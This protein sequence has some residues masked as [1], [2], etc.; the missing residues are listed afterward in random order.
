[1][2]KKG[3]DKDVIFLL[4]TTL[5]MLAT[6]VGLEVYRAYVKVNVAVDVEKHLTILTP[7]LDT[8]V[9]DELEKRSP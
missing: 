1:M 3:W 9:L 2:R 7:I 5:L 8:G 4:A 6:W